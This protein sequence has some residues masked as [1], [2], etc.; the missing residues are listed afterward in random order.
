MDW[1]TYQAEAMKTAAV[2]QE[3]SELETMA[4][5]GL[6]GEC[7]EVV[8]MLKKAVFHKKPMDVEKFK[9]EIGDCLWYLAVLSECYDCVIEI[10]SGHGVTVDYDAGVQRLVKW[11]YRVYEGKY[12]TSV[13]LEQIFDQLRS[14][15]AV[16]DIR[17]Q[18]AMELN[19]AK[20]RKRHGTSWS[21]G[22][23]QSDEWRDK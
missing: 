1:K 11:V 6:F 13:Y 5:W 8:D 20:L 14:F 16:Y 2:G 10:R 21:H 12:R 3:K 22:N 15:A 7:G 9:E 19:I 18:D 23:Y 4:R 17:I